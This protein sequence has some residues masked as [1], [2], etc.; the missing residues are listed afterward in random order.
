MSSGLYLVAGVGGTT[1]ALPAE[2]VEAVVRITALVPV[3]CAPPTII[4]LATIRS[5]VFTLL[6]TALIAGEGTAQSQ[7][8]A[9]SSIE[10][11][12]YGLALER[13]EDVIAIDRFGPA[14]AGLTSAW[15]QRVDGMADHQGRAI[16]LVRPEAIVA[17]AGTPLGAAA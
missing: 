14:P 4:G 12:G 17:C 6:D 9:I 7:L 5:R 3:P 8:M 11:H 2:T 1:I 13:V 16:L 15:A 10:G